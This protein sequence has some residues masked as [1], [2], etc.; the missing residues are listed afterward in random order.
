MKIIGGQ[1]KGRNFYRP[2]GIRPIQ[3]SVSKSLFDILGQ[4]LEGL[5]FLDLFAGSGSVGL[6]ALSRGAK[7][8]TFVEKDPKCAAIIT[9]NLKLLDV[10]AYSLIT[11][12]SFA[13]IKQITLQKQA[14]DI[15][16]SDPPYERDLGKKTLKTLEAYDILHPTSIVVIKHEKHEILPEEYGRFRLFRQKKYGSTLLSFYNIGEAG[17]SSQSQN[18]MSESGESTGDGIG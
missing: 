15:V 16:F 9:K 1:Y 14:Y 17:D 10:G 13:A 4:D 5:I 7:H 11:A 8:C 6:E 2:L 18:G 12:D 3:G